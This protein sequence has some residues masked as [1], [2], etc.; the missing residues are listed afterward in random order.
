MKPIEDENSPNPI[1]K[2][3]YAILEPLTKAVPGLTQGIYYMAK[4]KYILGDPDAA[5]IILSKI[6]EMK[7]V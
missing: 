4:V 6:L 2:K 7:T 1:L 5:K 3:C